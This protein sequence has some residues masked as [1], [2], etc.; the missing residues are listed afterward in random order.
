[1]PRFAQ[2]GKYQ[3]CLTIPTGIPAAG[4]TDTG[5]ACPIF[6]SCSCLLRQND[7]SLA[8]GRIIGPRTF[9][10]GHRG[11]PFVYALV[12]VAAT[13]GLFLELPVNEHNHLFNLSCVRFSSRFSNFRAHRTHFDLSTL[14]LIATV[15]PVPRRDPTTDPAGPVADPRGPHSH[16][17]PSQEF[18]RAPEGLKARPRPVRSD[19]VRRCL[20]DLRQRH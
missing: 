14:A 6:L 2:R 12:A 4:P 10:G 9:R 15:P 17:G 11:Q 1:M 20:L 16:P 5:L 7:H 19:A 18:P 8:P 3:S 13:F